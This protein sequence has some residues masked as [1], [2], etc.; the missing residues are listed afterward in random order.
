APSEERRS[1]TGPELYAEIALGQVGVCRHR[2]FA[3]TVTA[4]AL[5]IPTRFVHN[6]AHAWVEVYDA[7]LWHR[8]DLGGAAGDV[9]FGNA[10]DVPHVAPPDPHTWPAH[11]ESGQDMIDDAVG[12]TATVDASRS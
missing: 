9:S 7:K 5:G 4:L 1:E 10:L 12:E 11:S 8:I 3:F 6:E 2:S